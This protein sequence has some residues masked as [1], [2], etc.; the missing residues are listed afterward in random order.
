MCQGQE[1]TTHVCCCSRRHLASH[2]AQQGSPI[3]RGEATLGPGRFWLGDGHAGWAAG[4]GGV[5]A[6]QP[7]AGQEFHTCMMSSNI[8]LNLP[9]DDDGGSN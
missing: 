7:A 9:F 8:Y 6:G 4:R 5:H 1:P 2:P 3:Q